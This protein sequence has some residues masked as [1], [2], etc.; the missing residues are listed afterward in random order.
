MIILEDLN[1]K[2]NKIQKT[3]KIR[4]VPI[5]RFIVAGNS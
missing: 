4:P 3:T 1:N 2:L 5:L